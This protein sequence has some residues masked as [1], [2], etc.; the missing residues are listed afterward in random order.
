M[1]IDLAGA[2]EGH[3]DWRIQG[4]CDAVFFLSN[5]I[6]AYPNDSRKDVYNK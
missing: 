4:T 2:L 6:I 1:M 5:G 3:A